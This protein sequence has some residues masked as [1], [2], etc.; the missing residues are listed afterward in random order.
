MTWY[1]PLIGPECSHDLDT[2]LWLAFKNCKDVKLQYL[3]NSIFIES[4]YI[5]Y[6][7]YICHRP[8]DTVYININLFLTAKEAVQQA[9]RLI[10]ESKEILLQCNALISSVPVQFVS[11]SKEIL[12]HCNALIS[13][14]PVLFVSESKEIFPH[15]NAP[16]ISVPVLWQSWNSSF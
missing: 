12:P 2:S 7:T 13:S 15:C 10:S 4:F 11:E 14:V 8:L 16:I 9:I 3:Q 5:Y 1:W 6:T